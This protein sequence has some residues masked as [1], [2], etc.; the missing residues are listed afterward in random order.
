MY[1]AYD[2]KTKRNVRLNNNNF[3]KSRYVVIKD[4]S[5]GVKEDALP[6]YND[7]LSTPKAV[8]QTVSTNLGVKN[9]NGEGLFDSIRSVLG[10]GNT[11]SVA[12]NNPLKTTGGP[13]IKEA[14][15]KT[16]KVIGSSMKQPTPDDI[17]KE[18]EKSFSNFRVSNHTKKVKG[19]MLRAV[20]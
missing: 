8:K 10:F 5:S 3:D 4:F 1:L 6:Q 17:L 19:G 16:M 12:S 13:Y 7:D 2:R 18:V 9:V 14:P 11:V 20:I 15:K